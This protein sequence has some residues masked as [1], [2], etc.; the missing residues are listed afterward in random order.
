M[1]IIPESWLS[2]SILQKRI[3]CHWTVTSYDPD[4]VSI[5]SYH[6]VFDGDG[7]PHRGS[8]DLDE[9]AP[10]TYMFN[11]AIGLSLACMGGYI[12]PTSPGHYPPTKAQW[13]ALVEAVRQLCDRYSIPVTPTTVLMHGEVTDNLLVDQWG[14]WDIGWL[15]HL[16][17]SGAAACGDQLRREVLG[18]TDGSLD[19]EVAVRVSGHDKVVKGILMDGQTMV[20]IR[21]F[22]EASKLTLGKIVN[23]TIEVKLGSR[24]LGYRDM[25]LVGDTG[26]VELKPLCVS[27]GWE[28][29]IESW[30][31]DKR[32]VV[33]KPKGS[34]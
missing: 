29:G 19:K 14:K 25:L 13:D 10:H 6:I 18:S 4:P 1:S 31:K 24:S 17:L 26:Y 16:K 32:I 7:K 9:R 3:V 28:T 34:K 33:A 20:P 27:M 15:P 11:S 30:T 5:D 12:S 23:K 8:S 2:D 21:K 22:A